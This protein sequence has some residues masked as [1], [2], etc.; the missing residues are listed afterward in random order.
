[1]TLLDHVDFFPPD[2]NCWEWIGCKNTK[3]Y[4][5]Y[6]G[7]VAH[8]QVYEHFR[9]PVPAG[10]LLDHKCRNRSCVNPGHLEPVTPLENTRRG[11]G[12]GRKSVC[13][14]GHRYNDSN[15]RVYKGRRFCRTCNYLRR[16]S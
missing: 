14:R 12:N 1:M 6:R 8:K 2:S 11:H 9:G 5:N 10:N 16:Y 15:T 4:G 7:R 3:G 13:P